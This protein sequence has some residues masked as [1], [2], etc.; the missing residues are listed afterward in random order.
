MAKDV[1]PNEDNKEVRAWKRIRRKHVNDG[2]A[3]ETDLT[4]RDNFR[5]STFCNIIDILIVEMQKRK[6]FMKTFVVSFPV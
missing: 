1:L 5:V 3:S 6:A 4:P 2:N